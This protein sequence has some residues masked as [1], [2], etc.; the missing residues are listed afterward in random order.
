MVVVGRAGVR[1]CRRCSDQRFL[2]FVPRVREGT[3][4]DP[5]LPCKCGEGDPADPDCVCSSRR[6]CGSGCDLHAV[7]PDVPSAELHVELVFVP[8]RLKDQPLDFACKL[9]SF[10]ALRR[11]TDGGP[12]VAIPPLR[13]VL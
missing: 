10:A 9:S 5:D 12:E 4:C 7:V 13:F 1:L 6:C 3:E 8:L 2:Q 11:L